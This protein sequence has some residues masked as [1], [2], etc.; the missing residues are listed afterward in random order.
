MK[1][2]YA[3]LRS[4]P[5]TLCSLTGLRE[6]EFEALL[7]SFGDAWDDF[8]RETFEHEGRKRA[9]GAGRKAHLKGLE[10]KLLFILMYFRLYPTQ[11][12][13]GF[14]FSL[15]QAQ[16]NQWIHRL[17]GVLNQ[18]LGYERQLPEREPVNLETVLQNCPSLEF[19]LDGTERR[20]NRPQDKADRK[21]YYSGKKKAHTVKNLVIHDRQG[22]VRYLS[23]TYEGKKHDKKIA[24]EEDL[25]F[26]D[27]STLWQDTGSQGFAPAGVT[28]QQP[29]KKPRQRSLSMIEKMNNQ[30]ISSIRV[31]VEHH[32]GGIKRCQILVQPFR[33]WLDHFVDDVME[34]AC[35]LHNFR[36]THRQKQGNAA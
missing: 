36:L 24:E 19:M 16:A 2:T 33:N 6:S 17:T 25:Q 12:V 34:T 3:E 22:K 5:R 4:K 28:I 1:V 15:S 8:I 27:G 14:L 13:Q 10:D 29:K 21:Q 23:D 32:I 26:P 35:G 7:P 18:A 20:I 30:S 11:E 31:E 9:V